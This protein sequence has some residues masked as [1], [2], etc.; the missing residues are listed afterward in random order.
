[1]QNVHRSLSSLGITFTFFPIFFSFILPF[2]FT[3]LALWRP[4]RV[5]T[6]VE[7][8]RNCF[9]NVHINLVTRVQRKLTE[10]SSRKNL[11]FVAIIFHDPTYSTSDRF[12]LH[13]RR[14][15]FRFPKRNYFVTTALHRCENCSQMLRGYNIEFGVYGSYSPSGRKFVQELRSLR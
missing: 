4:V 1:M 7:I 10:I 6:Y 11:F 5:I 14:T 8:S 12:I 3:T 15:R 2:Y 13:F 9:L